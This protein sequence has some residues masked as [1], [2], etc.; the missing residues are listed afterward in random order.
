MRA[1]K[2]KTNSLYG[3]VIESQI[4]LDGDVIAD[5]KN[6]YITFKNVDTGLNLLRIKQTDNQLYY[7]VFTEGDWSDDIP[8]TLSDPD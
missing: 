8:L 6:K 3:Q 5:L 1:S 4:Q 7:N 2:N